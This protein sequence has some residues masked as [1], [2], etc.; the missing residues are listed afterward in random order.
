MVH[1]SSLK[2]CLCDVSYHG[3]CLDL[4]PFLVSFL[5]V[6]SDVGGWCCVEC[7]SSNKVNKPVA[8]P[9]KSTVIENIN[10]EITILKSQLETITSCLTN[11]SSSS[12]VTNSISTL[13]YAVMC[14]RAQ[15]CF[16]KLKRSYC[17]ANDTKT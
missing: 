15:Q 11:L 5:D 1:V 6:V 16:V 9:T 13:V 3:N 2:C 4:T 10:S 14:I 8:K 12:E 7:R 17:S